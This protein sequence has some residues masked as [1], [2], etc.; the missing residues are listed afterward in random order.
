MTA[1]RHRSLLLIYLPALFSTAS[2]QD[3]LVVRFTIEKAT[4][5]SKSTYANT[6]LMQLEES[7]R[8]DFDGHYQLKLDSL[9]MR[10]GVVQL[11]ATVKDLATGKPYY[12]GV[13]STELAIGDERTMVLREGTPAYRI[14]LD[15]AYGSLP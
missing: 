5:D 12:V 2:S 8:F 11:T 15:T 10:S 13:A 14:T 3:G 4:Q 6:V 9:P 7:V 1:S